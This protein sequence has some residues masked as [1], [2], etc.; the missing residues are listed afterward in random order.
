MKLRS[1]LTVLCSVFMVAPV[2]ASPMVF[3]KPAYTRHVVDAEDAINPWRPVKTTVD[4][5]YSA[6]L[7][8]FLVTE[9]DWY[10]EGS[11][12]K[13]AIYN[14]QGVL[15]TAFPQ[16]FGPFLLSREHST[17]LF[18]ESDVDE[19]NIEGALY[20]IDGKLLATLP[21]LGHSRDCGVS[22]D[23][24]LFWQRYTQA[25]QGKPVTVIRFISSLGELIK[26]LRLGQKQSVKL[27]FAGS[28]YQFEFDAP[29]FPI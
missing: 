7:D 1:F 20:S 24:K 9:T 6:T 21:V 16:A 29:Q 11:K 25:E 18:C 13:L 22:D 4:A 28:A 12:V 26:T 23:G 19:G 17:V 8:A 14:N 27:D 3:S 5:H 15:T 10:Y 2:M